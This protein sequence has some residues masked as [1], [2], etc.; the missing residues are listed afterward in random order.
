MPLREN[1]VGVIINKRGEVF[2]A[3][4]S[5]PDRGG[6]GQFPQG[7]VDPGESPEAAV[8]REMRE[9]TGSSGYEI[10]G[11]GRKKF[12]YNWRH[13]YRPLFSNTKRARGQRQTVFYLKYTAGH[14]DFKLNQRELSGYRWVAPPQLA[15]AIGTIREKMYRTAVEPELAHY[16]EI[17]KQH[18]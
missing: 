18:G 15:S 3:H 10:M 16:V 17:A 1:V 4:R 8:L 7:G 6:Q 9:E 12:Q 2:V 13:F 5:S 14:D 11:E